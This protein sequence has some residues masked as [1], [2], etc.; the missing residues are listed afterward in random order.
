MLGC[1][2]GKW[3]ALLLAVAQAQLLVAV[4]AEWAVEAG[5]IQLALG[6]A[7]AFCQTAMRRGIFSGLVAGFGL[8]GVLQLAAQAAVW[9]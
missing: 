5:Q 1:A 2:A 9:E 7:A 6:A 3:R 8:Q 4:E